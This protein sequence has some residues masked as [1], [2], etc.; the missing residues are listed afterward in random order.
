MPC[1][2]M[3][4]IGLGLSWCCS[5]FGYVLSLVLPRDS[6]ILISVIFA[7]LMGTFLSGTKPRLNSCPGASACACVRVPVCW[8]WYWY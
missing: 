4:A 1:A 6:M 7:I 2:G 5:G 8:H 3:I